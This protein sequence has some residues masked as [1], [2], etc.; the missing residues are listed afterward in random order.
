LLLLN[1]INTST[2]ASVL[3]LTEHNHGYYTFPTGKRT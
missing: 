2:V 1:S 3:L